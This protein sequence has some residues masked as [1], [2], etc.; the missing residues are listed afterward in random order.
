[1]EALEKWAL[2]SNHTINTSKE[3]K[4]TDHIDKSTIYQY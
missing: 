4:Q 3:G 2:S 1:M